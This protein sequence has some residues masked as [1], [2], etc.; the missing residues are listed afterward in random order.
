MN[1]AIE[2]S[3][4]IKIIL[5]YSINP[6]IYSSDAEKLASAT[7]II[8]DGVF[9]DVMEEEDAVNMKELKWLWDKESLTWNHALD[10]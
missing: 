5:G 3:E 10:T 4:G 8:V 6:D 7:H 1:N 9:P 2:I